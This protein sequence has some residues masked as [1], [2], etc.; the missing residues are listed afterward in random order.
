MLICVVLA[1]FAIA[2][3]STLVEEI[4]GVGT[5]GGAPPVV[6]IGD[7]G[8]N[9]VDLIIVGRLFGVAFPNINGTV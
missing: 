9:I 5:A 2:T 4:V 3:F 8:E 6:G 7:H 1:Y